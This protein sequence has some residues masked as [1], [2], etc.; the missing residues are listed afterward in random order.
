MDIY[1]KTALVSRYFQLQQ[2]FHSYFILENTHP[3]DEENIEISLKETIN[4]IKQYIKPQE[5]HSLINL[6]FDKLF[7]ANP[8]EKSRFLEFE[9][10]AEQLITLLANQEKENT[11]SKAFW[12]TVL[13]GLL[14]VTLP[15]IGLIYNGWVKH[16]SQ[17]QIL[18]QGSLARKPPTPFQ[19]RKQASKAEEKKNAA[20]SPESEW[21]TLQQVQQLHLKVMIHNMTKARNILLHQDPFQ[22][23]DEELDFTYKSHEEAC[24]VLSKTP[25]NRYTFESLTGGSL[26]EDFEKAIDKLNKDNLTSGMTKNV[27]PF[28]SRAKH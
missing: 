3:A 10:N 25:P 21:Q 15:F 5:I 16:F 26:I 22:L 6:T 9:A 13:C 19:P 24:K 20:T 12:V 23:D 27:M 17:K 18:Q 11:H 14:I 7:L 2:K 8:I 4:D 1:Q 28:S